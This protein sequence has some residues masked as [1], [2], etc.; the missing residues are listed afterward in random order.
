MALRVSW[1]VELQPL[2]IHMCA[3]FVCMCTG[4]VRMCTGFVC[5]CTG[6]VRVCT[7]FVRVCHGVTHMCRNNIRDKTR[8]TRISNAVSERSAARHCAQSEDGLLTGFRPRPTLSAETE[9]RADTEMNTA[10]THLV[11]RAPFFPLRRLVAHARSFPLR[12][13]V[14]HAPSFPFWRARSP[15]A[16]F[17][18]LTLI[19]SVFSPLRRHHRL[20]PPPAAT[21]TGHAKAVTRR[22]R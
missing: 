13:L 21:V 19:L 18:C 17:N 4:F 14:T 20:L 3:G 11:A 7:G 1:V 2:G 9:R 12:R 22:A 8:S 5:M 6:F 16:T 15:F 10:A